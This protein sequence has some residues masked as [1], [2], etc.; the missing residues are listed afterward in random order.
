M[1]IV[2]EHINEKFTKES[3]PLK[4]MGIGHEALIKKW[5]TSS[6]EVT[7]DELNEV[8]RINED[9]EI[10]LLNSGIKL[11][12]KAL[13]N[14]E[15]PEYIQFNEIG[16]DFVANHCGLKSLRGCPKYVK[17]S[18]DCSWNELTSLEHAPVYVRFTFD[19]R[20]NKEVFF[21]KDVRKKIDIGGEVYDW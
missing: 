18:F 19:C 11:I 7:I 15:L 6:F 21:E 9:G 1:K 4:D 2:R 16:G 3:D 14:G 13:V 8:M 17:G 20:H 12:A 10:D 5:F